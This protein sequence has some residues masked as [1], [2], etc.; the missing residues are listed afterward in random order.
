MNLSTFRVV[1]DQ[2]LQGHSRDM[3]IAGSNR[4]PDLNFHHFERIL[5][6]IFG[7]KDT[8]FEVF[9]TVIEIRLILFNFCKS[10]KMCYTTMNKKTKI[11]Y[12]YTLRSSTKAACTC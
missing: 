6:C 8:A 12:I 2:S 1:H 3:S 10:C 7:G 4:A 5:K 11:S 9:K